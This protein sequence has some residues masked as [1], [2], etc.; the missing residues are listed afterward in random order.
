MNKKNILYFAPFFLSCLYFLCQSWHFNLHDFSNAYFAALFLKIGTFD[1]QIYNALDFNNKIVHSGF[2]NIFAA[3]Y[4][5]TPFFAFFF[6]PFSFLQPAFAKLSFNIISVLLLSLVTFR[7]WKQFE[8]PAYLLLLLPL[9]FYIPIKTNILYGQVYFLLSYLLLA[10]LLALQNKKNIMGATCWG[11]A[12]LLKI[13]PALL[14]FYLFIHKQFKFILYFGLACLALLILSL[15]FITPTHWSYYLYDIFPLANKGILYD[16]FTPAA[17]S[18]N[19]LFRNI[20]IYDEVLNPK[21]FISSILLYKITVAAYK[22]TIISA[23]ILYTLKNK[24]N[25]LASFSVWIMTALLLTPNQSYYAGILLLFPFVAIWQKT[26]KVSLKCQWFFTFVLCLCCNIPIKYFLELPLLFKFPKFW[27]LLFLFVMF[28]FLTTAADKINI[29]VSI[30]IAPTVFL[31]LLLNSIFS[32]SQQSNAYVVKEKTPILITD[33]DHVDNKIVYYYQ[34]P[35]GI[36]PKNTDITN[37][38]FDTTNITIKN[39]Q[40]FYK[41]KMLTR[42]KGNKQKAIQV[43]KNEIFF[44]SDENRAPGF[45]TLRKVKITPDVN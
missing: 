17:K 31:L 43:N 44:L 33:Y 32:V 8:P 34:T 35:N 3:Y 28:Y 24:D 30:T 5:N 11:V 12:V 36:L 9:I 26:S 29:K 21:P 7:C 38:L 25:L 13:F 10:G 18:A 42:N 16:G 2:Q 45:Y 23:S 40:I 4:P 39:N 37:T 15:S 27:L 41:E 22:T 14:V 20:F 19:M 1:T 6:L